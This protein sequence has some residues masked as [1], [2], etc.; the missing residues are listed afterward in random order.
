MRARPLPTFDP[1]EYETDKQ[2]LRFTSACIVFNVFLIFLS[3]FP[4]THHSIFFPQGDFVVPC[5]GAPGTPWLFPRAEA[6]PAFHQRGEDCGSPAGHGTARGL[7]MAVPIGGWRSGALDGLD[8][9]GLEKPCPKKAIMNRSP[10][11][12]IMIV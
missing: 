5:P 3:S 7:G 6:L 4:C 9:M 10:S 2:R 12:S 11:G 1:P 8:G